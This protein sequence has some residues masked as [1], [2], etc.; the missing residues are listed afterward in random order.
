MHCD[1]DLPAYRISACTPRLRGGA[2][3]RCLLSQYVPAQ[4]NADTHTIIPPSR[5]VGFNPEVNVNDGLLAD[6]VMRRHRLTRQ[7]AMDAIAVE[8]ESLRHQL[9][10][11]GNVAIG[12]IG[13]L[14]AGSESGSPV[15][16]PLAS[17]A[18]LTRYTG[19]PEIGMPEI[20][21]PEKA[22]EPKVAV[23]EKEAICRGFSRWP[24][25]QSQPCA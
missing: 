14:H 2:T 1:T 11:E 8:V 15:F 10:E 12:R 22:G 4:F 23:R 5:S 17:A 18:V 19:L 7:A 25:R 13:I 9:C 16:E 6:S 21:V 20:T 3:F 24:R